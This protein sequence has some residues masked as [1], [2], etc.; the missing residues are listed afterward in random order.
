MSQSLAKAVKYI[1]TPS[2]LLNV[3]KRDLYCKDLIVAD[4]RFTGS[5]T[6]KYQSITF[7][8]YVMDTFSQSTG[9]DATGIVSTWKTLTLTQDK[10]NKLLIDRIVEDEEV[11]ATGLVTYVNR[12]IE[13]VQQPAVDTYVFG[14]IANKTGVASNKKTL[15]N[16]STLEE[17][18]KAFAVLINN[19]IK[20]E[21]LILYCSPTIK[22]FLDEQTFGKGIITLGTWNGEVDYQ[23]Q[24]ING[25]KIVVVPDSR[26]PSGVQFILVH[27]DA[28]PVFVKFQETEFFDKIPGFGSRKMQAD[29]GIYY[30]SFVYDELVKGV[31]VSKVATYTLAFEDG[32]AVGGAVTA[33]PTTLPTLTLNEGQIITLPASSGFTLET[34]DFLGWNVTDAF[35]ASVTYLDEGLYVMGAANATLYGAWVLK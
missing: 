33:S 6:V 4:A 5:D 31:F 24:M 30:D 28:C 15:A 17:L 2:E 7:D 26:L 13:T 34:H 16:T 1:K 12:Y 27:K 9:Y 32:N 3:L 19:D 11:T 22:A 29:I 35:N 10:G 23:V 25:A 21:R 14:V 18:N 20:T 8:S